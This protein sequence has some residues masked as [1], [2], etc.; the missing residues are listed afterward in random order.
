MNKIVAI[1]FFCGVGGLTHGLEN[2]GISV[3]KGIDNDASVM[4]TY[5]F[6]NSSTF[7]NKDINQ[8]DPK[9]L[10]DKLNIKNRHLLFAG[11]V[12][13]QPFSQHTKNSNYDRRKSLIV[14][15]LHFVEK[16][17]PEFILVENVPGFSN[18]DNYHRKKFL[19]S[20]KNLG[21]YVDEE[22]INAA[23]F[24]IPQTR[25]RYVLLASKIAPIKMPKKTHGRSL[26]PY[27]TV[28]D[29]ISKY[30]KIKAGEDSKIVANQISPN[31]SALNLKRLKHIPKDG[32]SRLSLPKKLQLECHKKHN[33]HSDVYGRMRWDKPAP[34]LT[35]KCTSI[36]NGRFVHPEQNRSVSV[37]EAAA[38][39]TFP[40]NYIFYGGK[41]A[42]A[43]HI[44][45]AVPVLLGKKLGT[46][47][48]L[49]VKK[50][51]A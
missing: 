3:L 17:V 5:E 29:T 33:T 19:R 43:R 35:C 49:H 1:D 45:N 42:C 31:I 6:N 40:D 22:I 20:I 36:S 44:G 27:K 47:F 34:T 32:G 8:L 13:C 7:I 11:C 18:K 2:A 10:S 51:S 12:P 16:M 14:R 30:P 9:L 46:V 26:I 41:T 48:K 28:R 25:K 4:K 37:R 23:D 15:F 21:Y 38:L 39:Q 50:F 24:G